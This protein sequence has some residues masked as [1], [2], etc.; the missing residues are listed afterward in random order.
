MVF[1]VISDATL[2]EKKAL[3]QA[4]LR[5][6]RDN[7]LYLKDNV[8]GFEF[9]ETSDITIATAVPTGTLWSTSQ[10]L[11]IPTKGLIIFSV[12]AR[13]DNASGVGR[14]YSFG[15]RIN[16]TDYWPQVDDNGT[17]VY[18][19]FGTVSNGEYATYKGAASAT[20]EDNI[21]FFA[22]DIEG[23]GISTGAQTVQ[24]IIATSGTAATQT[25]KGAT[26]T[27]HMGVTIINRN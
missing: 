10:S 23:F 20:A 27:A 22:L 19:D 18:F 3:T 11:A 12:F 6:F 16:G 14:R 21:V 1:T 24:P 8:G 4:V 25:L 7:D 2:T 17:P 15:L 5:Q 26:V 9:T 13:V